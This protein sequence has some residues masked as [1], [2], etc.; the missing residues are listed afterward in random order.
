MQ[1]LRMDFVRNQPQPAWAPLASGISP[2]P[3][4]LLMRSYGRALREGLVND[5]LYVLLTVVVFA[6]LFL[7]VKGVERFER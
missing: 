6:V 4:C 7:L 2:V 3:A 5:F 1:V